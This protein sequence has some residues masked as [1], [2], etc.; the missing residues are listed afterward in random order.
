MML[1]VKTFA[2]LD[3]RVHARCMFPTR[4][5]YIYKDLLTCDM[6]KNDC[7]SSVINHKLH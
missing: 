7:N 6:D 5:L 1:L 4:P 3:I 2:I